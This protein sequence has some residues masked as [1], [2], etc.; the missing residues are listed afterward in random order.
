[1]DRERQNDGCE[2]T[3]Q[4]TGN[5]HQVS[6]ARKIR[7][8][9][10]SAVAAKGW[11]RHA[12]VKSAGRAA[13]SDKT[14]CIRVDRQEGVAAVEAARVLLASLLSRRR[15][16]CSRR[17]KPMRRSFM[18]APSAFDDIRALFAL[19]PEASQQAMEA[20]AQRQRRL[21]KP[22]GSSGAS[23]SSSPGLPGGKAGTCRQS[24]GRLSP[25]LPAITASWRKAFR[26]SRRGHTQ[27]VDEFFRRRCG[28]R[29]D[30]ARPSASASKFRARARHADP[31]HHPVT[32]LWTSGTP[33]RP[34]PSAWKRSPMAP[35]C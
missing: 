18:P 20:V 26:L 9:V 6:G 17:C 23:K 27:M 8:G 32:R 10:L 33:P 11:E 25:S 4:R 12:R 29:P 21:T 15:A 22:A 2:D 30:S 28:D 1:M 13:K 24:T 14:R 5:R 16:F 3:D 31:R 19:M 34:S 35:I 7:Y